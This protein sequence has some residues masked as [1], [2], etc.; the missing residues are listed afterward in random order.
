MQLTPQ[1]A[2]AIKEVETGSGSIVLS[3]VAG[4]G[5]TS[6]L[7]QMLKATEGSVAFC[8]FN[9]SIA[10]EIE[11]KVNQQNI[12]K[13]VKVGTV[14]SFGFGAIRRSISRVNVDGNKI[15]TIVRDNFNN[16]ESNMQTFLISAVAMA[17]EVGIRACVNDNYNTWIQMFDHYDLWNSLPLDVNT[18]K[19]IGLCQDVLDISNKTL[20]VV[21][22]SDMIYLPILKKMRIWKYSNIF[23]D[24]AQDTNATRRALVKMMLAPKGRLIAVG[25][26]HQAIYG[27]TGADSNALDLI[28]KEFKAKEL[29][30]SVTFRCPKNVVKE[31]QKYVQHIESHPDSADGIVDECNLQDLPNLV[32]QEDAIICRNTKPL[33]EVAYN[34]IR[35]KIPCKVEGRK[36]GENLIKLATRWKVKTVGTLINKLEA[37]KEKEIEKYKKKE[38][39]SMCQVIEDQVET[40]AVFIDQC[41]LDDSISTLV[42]KIQELF[43]DTENKKILVLSTIHRSKGREWNRVF[44]LGI[45]HYSPSKY[46]KKDWELVQE[47]NLLYVLV[48]R[49]KN[50]LTK[51]NV[52]ETQ[53]TS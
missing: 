18:D 7:I 8:A 9:K 23:L 52:S 31:A 3:A 50:H 34:L 27:F 4:A 48:T 21:D 12:N 45:N 6:V 5:K 11:F 42:K 49:A 36:I 43:D 16:E 10:K 35:N 53:K 14:H 44:A 47:N 32:T 17:K 22:F 30:L 1:Q 25:D 20:N 41:K 37:Y 39:E 19:A 33:V 46:A 15:Q 2:A 24:E 38:N 51:V 28:Q 26:P 40:L 13:D 29:P